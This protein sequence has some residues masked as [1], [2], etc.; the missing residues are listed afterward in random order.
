SLGQLAAGMAHEINNPVA[1]VANNLAVLKRDV[2]AAM[3]VLE[4]Y[5]K[6]R[7]ALA[8]AAPHLAS[9]AAEME[10]ASDLEWIRE[11]R[12]Q[13]FAASLEGLSRVRKIVSNLRDFAHL[14]QAEFDELDVNAALQSTAQVLHHEIE[15][16][17]LTLATR[18]A[19]LAPLLCHPAKINQVLHNV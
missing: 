14:D 2:T 16:K 1:F 18:F 13:L 10:A 6:G 15:E 17:K 12:P 4:K 11:N 3:A 8:R 19:K 7:G 5:R 9:E